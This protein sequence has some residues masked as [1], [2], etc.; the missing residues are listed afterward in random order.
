[1]SA[2]AVTKGGSMPL[3]GHLSELRKR[4]IICIVPF[5][6]LTAAF[7][8]MAD[9]LVTLLT[10]MGKGF[11]YQYVYLAPQE[12]MVE[13]LRIAVVGAAVCCVPLIL[14]QVWSFAQPGLKAGE[15]RMF[16]FSMVFGLLC[17][18]VGVLFAYRITLPFMLRFLIGLRSADIS[19]AI[20][21]EKYIG[22]LLTVFLIFGVVFEMP[23][24]SV[25]LT[26]LGLIRSQW[27]RKARKPA[28]VVI[29]L[30]AA[31]ITPPDIFSQIMVAVPMILL[32]QVSILLSAVFERKRTQEET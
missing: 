22:F 8:P 30:L 16:G 11:G 9:R 6:V 28:I 1:M 23:L 13:Y 5:V 29:F 32:Y 10:D 14:F 24:L 20:S 12:L 25:V 15:R 18:G 2:S 7:L 17:F 27:L 3:T 31:I 26:N 19:A 21:I 4:L